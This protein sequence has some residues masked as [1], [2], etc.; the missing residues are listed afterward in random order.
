VP[1]PP[2]YA[3]GSGDVLSIVVWDHPELAGRRHDGRHRARRQRHERQRNANAPQRAS[4]S[5]TRG[6]SSFPS[7]GLLP[8]TA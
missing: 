6:A 1:N 8:S 7:I 3:I 5:T 2:P 4:W